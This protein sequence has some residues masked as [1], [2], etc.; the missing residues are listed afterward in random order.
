VGNRRTKQKSKSPSLTL[1]AMR[2]LL[3]SV[4][5]IAFQTQED[6]SSEVSIVEGV[7][8]M[9]QLA[10]A[11]GQRGVV[12]V[13]WRHESRVW[14][15]GGRGRGVDRDGELLLRDQV[16]PSLSQL[17]AVGRGENRLSCSTRRGM[18]A[19]GPRNRHIM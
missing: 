17:L 4:M 5:F 7:S 10:G 16:P 11:L 14:R 12:I 15:G 1:A 3:S 18:S 8:H 2:R 19:G 6:L 9:D 13:G